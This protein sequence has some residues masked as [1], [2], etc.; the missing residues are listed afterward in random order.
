MSERVKIDFN[1]INEKDIHIIRNVGSDINYVWFEDGHS[2]KAPE[3]IFVPLC[4]DDFNDLIIK[5][6]DDNYIVRGL[7][8]VSPNGSYMSIL[9]NNDFSEDD[10]DDYVS[11]YFHLL[12]DIQSNLK[13]RL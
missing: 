5:D 10:E 7:T 2:T 11:S 6:K 13:Y 3:N 9:R 1:N 8:L 4:A 12:E